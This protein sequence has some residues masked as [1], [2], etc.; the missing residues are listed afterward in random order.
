MPEGPDRRI[1]VIDVD[2]ANVAA[3]QQRQ[4]QSATAGEGLGVVPPLQL[5]GL[6]Q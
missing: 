4:G 2:I 5:V 3:I 1:Q 6:E